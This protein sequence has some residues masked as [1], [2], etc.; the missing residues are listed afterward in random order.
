MAG[1]A[2]LCRWW[3]TSGRWSERARRIG[4]AM[5]RRRRSSCTGERSPSGIAFTCSPGSRSWSWEPAAVSGP[6]ISLGAPGRES[7]Y[8]SGVQP[9]LL[10][11][12]DQAWPCEYR[13]RPPRRSERPACRELRLRRRHSDPLSRQVR[14]E[15]EAHPQGPQARGADPVL[16]GRTTGTPRSSRRASFRLWAVGRETRAVRLACASFV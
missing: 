6:N 14:R 2:L 10:R 12:G 5:R 8:G 7:H 3:T 15:P 11:A 4:F 16:R 9:R 13:G 1:G